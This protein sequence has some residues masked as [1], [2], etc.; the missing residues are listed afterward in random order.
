VTQHTIF[1]FRA[2]ALIGMA[3]HF[4]THSRVYAIHSCDNISMVRRA[5]LAMSDDALGR[6]VDLRDPLAQEDLTFVRQ[7]CVEDFEHQLSI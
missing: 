7:V 6:M 5:I 2:D 4:L 1:L 3:P